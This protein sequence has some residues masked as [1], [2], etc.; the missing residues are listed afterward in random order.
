MS[1][2]DPRGGG[3]SSL[4]GEKSAIFPIFNYDASPKHVFKHGVNMSSIMVYSCLRKLYNKVGL[5]WAMLRLAFSFFDHISPFVLHISLPTEHYFPIFSARITARLS[6]VIFGF[7]IFSP[8]CQMPWGNMEL[9]TRY[10]KKKIY[11]G[12]FTA[13]FADCKD[14]CK[15]FRCKHK[16]MCYVMPTFTGQNWH[17]KKCQ[18]KYF[19]PTFWIDMYE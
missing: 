5:S 11:F 19:K 13:S 2:I 8:K 7:F 17:F 9:S 1:E 14:H 15:I 10:K 4:F 3:G 18:R 6:W 12:G 16:T